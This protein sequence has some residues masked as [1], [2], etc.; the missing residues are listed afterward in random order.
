VIF[1][2]ICI[3]VQKW[4]ENHQVLQEKSIVTCGIIP[5]GNGRFGE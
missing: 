3:N 4:K 5:K 1:A 2:D